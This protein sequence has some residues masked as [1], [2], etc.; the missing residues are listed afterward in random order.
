MSLT[1]KEKPTW[2]TTAIS[3]GTVDEPR[4]VTRGKVRLGSRFR[5]T[6]SFLGRPVPFEHRITEFERP[7]RLVLQV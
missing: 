1:K 7:S 2:P 3:A 5:L 6:V 4:R